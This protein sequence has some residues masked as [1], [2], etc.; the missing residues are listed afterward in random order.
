MEFYRLELG[1]LET[2]WCQRY[3]W[4]NKESGFKS[5]IAV[6]KSMAV[7]RVMSATVY[8]SPAT[9]WVTANSSLSLS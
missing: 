4:V 1:R 5:T 8:L 2:S 6:A 3:R 9:N 7:K